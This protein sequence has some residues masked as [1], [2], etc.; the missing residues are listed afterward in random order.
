MSLEEIWVEASH[1]PPGREGRGLNGELAAD[2]DGIRF[3]TARPWSILRLLS[4]VGAGPSQW[5]ATYAYRW[6]EIAAVALA[7]RT[8]RL[9]L[10][11]RVVFPAVSLALRDGSS[12]SFS[13]YGSGVRD[14]FL[15]KLR[16]HV[17]QP[18][19]DEPEEGVSK[20]EPSR[21]SESGE[22]ERAGPGCRS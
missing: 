3:E 2:A 1:W 13:F 17:T 11:W 19:L 5:R 15:S 10:V 14:L 8:S 6:D 12:V 7:E 16:M 22:G 9:Y 21:L 4:G 20:R 18:A